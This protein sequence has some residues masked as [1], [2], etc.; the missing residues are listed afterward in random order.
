MSILYILPCTK[1]KIWDTVPQTLK[2]QLACD[3]YQGQLFIKA[4]KFINSQKT[5][6]PSYLI[7]STKYGFIYPNQSIQ[8]YNETFNSKKPNFVF[9][10]KQIREYGLKPQVVIILGGSVYVNVVRKVFRNSEILTPLRGLSIGKMLQIL[11]KPGVLKLNIEDFIWNMFDAT[12][13]T[14]TNMVPGCHRTGPLPNLDEIETWGT[15]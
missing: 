13:P 7:L 2:W 10:S 8:N 12:T 9:L 14:V 3:A 11:D 5:S 6:T 4:R 1:T 15:K